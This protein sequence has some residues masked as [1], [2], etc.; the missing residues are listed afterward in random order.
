M[1]GAMEDIVLPVKDARPASLGADESRGQSMLGHRHPSLNPLCPAVFRRG[2]KRDGLLHRTFPIW[3]GEIHKI[4]QFP[5]SGGIP[6][7]AVLLGGDSSDAYAADDS[8][9]PLLNVSRRKET[10]LANTEPLV[11]GLGWGRCDEKRT[12]AWREKVRETRV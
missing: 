1:A 8:R 2:Q 3:E 12:R 7:A 6:I 11:A 5:G 9:G 10:A 4:Y